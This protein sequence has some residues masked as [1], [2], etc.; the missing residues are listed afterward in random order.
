M[1][2]FTAMSMILIFGLCSGC[3]SKYGEQQTQVNYYP[4][5]YQPIQDLRSGEHNVAKNTGAGALLGAFTGAMIGLIATGK[6]QGALMGG[7]VGGAA[8]SMAGNAYGRHQQQQ[9]DNV[10]MAGYLQ[11]LDGDISNLDITHA[12]AR[13]SLQCYDRAFA[14]LLAEIRAKQISRQAAQS[15]FGEIMSGREEAINILGNA[16][17]YGQNLNQEYENAFNSEEQKIAENKAESSATRQQKSRAVSQARQRKQTLVNKT[18]QITRDRQEAVQATS[19]QTREINEAYAAL[20]DIR[21]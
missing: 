21:S 14:A 5:C 15:R 11:N 2:K 3:A 9:D 18:A 12:A 16:A 13:T 19:R 4:A 10:R 20:Q 1:K 8:G 6:W 17:Q 7:A